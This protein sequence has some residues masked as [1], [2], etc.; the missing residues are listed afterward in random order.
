MHEV[1]TPAAVPDALCDAIKPQVI[2]HSAT[3]YEVRGR[4][5]PHHVAVQPHARYFKATCSCRAGQ[6]ERAC[7]ALIAVLREVQNERLAR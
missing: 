7:Y 1:N 2:K 5:D 6:N 3:H 4:R